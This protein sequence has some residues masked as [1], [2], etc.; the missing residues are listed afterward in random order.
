MT[1]T[2]RFNRD[3]CNYL[4]NPQLNPT[5]IPFNLPLL[6]HRFIHPQKIITPIYTHTL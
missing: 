4:N 2:K 5:P 6:S 1:T 3:H